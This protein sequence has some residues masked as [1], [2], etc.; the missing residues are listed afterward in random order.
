MLIGLTGGIGSGKST[1]LDIFREQGF[2]IFSCDEE[3]K[4]LYKK[5]KVLIRLKKEFP[6]A[7]KGIIF[8]KADKKIIADEIFKNKKKYDFLTDFLA[9]A[10][11]NS[12]IFKAKKQKCDCVIEV[13][14]LFE[15]DLADA[16][17]KVVIIK[18]NISDRKKS[19]MKRSSLSEEEIS[20]RINAQA[21]YEK[22]DLSPYIVIEN[23]GTIED[24]KE[25]IKSLSDKLK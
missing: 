13:P 2:K 16:F 24:L 7:I 10:A 9:T 5:R 22:L 12:V 15:K 14:L 21:D 4:D 17:D 6:Q 19:V 25:K 11:F 23:N 3:V 18:R 8:L 20:P 1:A